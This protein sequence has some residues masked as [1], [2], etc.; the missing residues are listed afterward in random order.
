MKKFTSLSAI[1]LCTVWISYGQWTYT[2]LSEPKSHMG[3]V[4]LGTKTYFAGGSNGS[5]VVSL[6][7]S[8]DVET[9]MWDTPGNLSVARHGPTCVA[10]GT[11]ILIAGGMDYDYNTTF[12]TVDILDTETGEWKVKQL[13]LDRV[14]LAAVSYGNKVLFAGGVQFPNNTFSIVDIYDVETEEWSTTNLSQNRCGM[15]SA[16]VGDQ[17]FFAGGMVNPYTFSDRVDIYNFTSGTWT[18]DTLSQARMCVSATTVGDKI[19]FAGGCIAMNEPTDTVDIYDASENSWTTSNLSFP[20]SWIGNAATV[21]GKAYFA[22]GGIWNY[23]FYAP[24]NVI[25]IYDSTG[26]WSTD[27]LF[28]PLVYHAVVSSGNYLVIAGGINETNAKTALVEIFYDPQT[29]ITSQSNEDTFLDIFPNPAD[30]MVTI[31]VKNGTIIKE[32]TIYNQVGQNV[33]RGLPNDNTLDVS[34]IQPG[35]Y[36]IEVI[37]DQSEIRE[38]LII[39]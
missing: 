25:D 17:A 30:Q 27:I 13:S 3:S 18:T 22:G 6:V 21:N 24:S 36:L 5:N 9:G 12:S 8:Y 2:S 14:D 39:E 23:G 7:E 33:Y 15:A 16:V 35:V 31:S 34:Q 32:V 38:K 29:G 10:C 1:L 11:K 26:T 19:L 37:T 4:S 20:R 28:E